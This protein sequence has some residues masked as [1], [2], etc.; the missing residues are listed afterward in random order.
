MTRSDYEDRQNR[1]KERLLERAARAEE[2]GQAAY[3]AAD[4]IA[5]GIPLGQPIL[6]GHH[7][8]RGH[9]ADLKRI[10]RGMTKAVNKA[11]EAKELR[12]RAE[13]VGTA[14]VSSDDPDALKKLRWKLRDLEARRE[15]RKLI[16]A[17]WRKA[18]RPTPDDAAAWSKLGD[19]VGL[20]PAGVH[21]LRL[22]LAKR[23]WDPDGTP[24]PAYSLKNTGAEIRRL[25]KRIED[26]ERAA[27]Q[28]DDV[29]KDVG[30]CRIV[31]NVGAGRIQLIFDGKPKDQVRATLKRHGFRWS[32]R[33][34]AWQRLLNEAGRT[35]A[36]IVVQELKGGE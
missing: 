11:A 36:R 31:E 27:E 4:R 20:S 35:A 13:A 8:E 21:Q 34:G 5:K 1:R 17:A 22:E 9:R 24:F 18:G 3:D 16:N 29:E 26:L 25:K 23:S 32:P 10:D 7:S 28:T 19:D 14:G 2:E 6:I 15:K 33:E 12:R 30:V